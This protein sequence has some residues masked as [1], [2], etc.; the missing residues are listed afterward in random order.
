MTK[1]LKKLQQFEKNVFL[2]AISAKLRENIIA[3]KKLII[4]TI[5]EL[6]TEKG[7]KQNYELSF[8]KNV[9]KENFG[10]ILQWVQPKISDLTDESTEILSEID[11]STPNSLKRL[12]IESL[13]FYISIKETKEKYPEITFDFYVLTEHSNLD[14]YSLKEINSIA[15]K[16]LSESD[17]IIE[18]KDN[19]DDYRISINKYDKDDNEKNKTIKEYLNYYIS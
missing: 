13:N 4:G 8:D 3:E 12:K 16:I 15:T 14:N 10:I 11:K 7:F 18:K 2:E 9:D 6:L 17:I 19:K 5:E 1:I